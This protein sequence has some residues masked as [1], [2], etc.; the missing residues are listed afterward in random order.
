MQARANA[1]HAQ[2]VEQI[3]KHTFSRTLESSDWNNVHLH[4]DAREILA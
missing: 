3:P 2:W 4:S 1:Q